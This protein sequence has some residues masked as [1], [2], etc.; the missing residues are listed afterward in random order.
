[1]TAENAGKARGRSALLACF[2]EAAADDR[3]KRRRGA[4]RTFGQAARFNEAAADDRGKQERR[5][6][7]HRLRIGFNEAAADDRG[8]RQAAAAPPPAAPP[9]Q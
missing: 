1:M 6:Y 2:N 9:L 8:K 7:R 4:V 5:A 3:G